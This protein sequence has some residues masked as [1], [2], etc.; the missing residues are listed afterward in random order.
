M[1]RHAPRHTE[2]QRDGRCCCR[3][4]SAASLGCIERLKNGRLENG[5]EL[6]VQTQ[7]QIAV[8][9]SFFCRTNLSVD[10]IP[11]WSPNEIRGVSRRIAPIRGS[12]TDLLQ[13]G[14][15]AHTA[16]EDR[17][18]G[19]TEKFLGRYAGQLISKSHRIR[20]V[21]AGSLFATRGWTGRSGGAGKFE[22]GRLGSHVCGHPG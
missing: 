4:P 17:K 5:E 16:S 20:R 13:R 14:Q 1:D 3:Q 6:S 10:P 7:P 2:S 12:E 22:T 21:M 15:I 11:R 18:I 19:A 8:A 9:H